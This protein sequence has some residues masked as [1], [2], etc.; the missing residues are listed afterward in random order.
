VLSWADADATR[1]DA[2]RVVIA[3]TIIVPV[4]VTAELNINALGLGRNSERRTTPDI[5][6]RSFHFLSIH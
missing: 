6:G 4:A 5:S 2:D 1:A 3:A